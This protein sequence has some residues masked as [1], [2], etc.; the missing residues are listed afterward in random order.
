MRIIRQAWLYFL[1][2][3]G[4]GFVFGV[5]RTLIFVP[6]IGV[7]WAE[8][9]EMPLML[10]VIVLAALRLFRRNSDQRSIVE[11]LSIGGIALILLLAMEF[12]L[13][14]AFQEKSISQYVFDR[15]PVSGIAYLIILGL[16]TIMPCLVANPN[17]IKPHLQPDDQSAKRETGSTHRHANSSARK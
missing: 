8:L 13:A 9:L 6:M 16:Y 12:G 11:L 1:I 10:G 14:F 15:D 4:A 3:F 5:I 17:R 7:R 2:V